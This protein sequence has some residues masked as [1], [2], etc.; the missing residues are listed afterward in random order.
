VDGATN[1]TGVKYVVSQKKYSTIMMEKVR[2]SGG[3]AFRN[4]YKFCR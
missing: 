3:M 1:V 4:G 2:P